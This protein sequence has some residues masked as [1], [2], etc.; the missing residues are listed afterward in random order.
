MSI[1]DDLKKR[2]IFQWAVAY[3]AGAWVLM[4]LIDVIGSDAAGDLIVSISE[5]PHELFERRGEDFASADVLARYD[6]LAAFCERNGLA[7]EGRWFRK[8]AARTSPPQSH[9]SARR[10]RGSGFSMRAVRRSRRWSR[11]PQR[12]P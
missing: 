5:E 9:C 11:P 2:K 6:A 8:R 4:Q 12:L 7:E 10:S 3:L 1:F